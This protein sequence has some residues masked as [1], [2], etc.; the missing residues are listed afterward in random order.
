MRFRVFGKHG[1]EQ[2]DIAGDADTVDGLHA[3]EIPFYNAYVC[4]RDKKALGSD[5]GA[6]TSGAWRTR[7][8]NDEQAD[9]AGICSIASNQITLAAGTYRCNISCPA[10]AVDL[11]QTRLYNVTDAAVLL[12]GTTE[13][14]SDTAYSNTRSFIVGCFTLAAEKVLEVQH[15]C[16]TT[17][18]FRGFG[19]PASWT[20]EIY[21]VAEFERIA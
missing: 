9:T 6:F 10:H 1:K 5:G 2:V 4:V 16:L 20:D 13:E 19:T 21:A 3:A 18:L 14:T 12:T 8:I 17:F 11:H 7:D 15:Q